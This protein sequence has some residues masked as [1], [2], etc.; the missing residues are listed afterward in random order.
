[1]STLDTAAPPESAGHCRDPARVCLAISSPQGLATRTVA[2]RM[3]VG[4]GGAR[5]AVC[6][7]HCP[8]G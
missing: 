5:L 3:R 2:W 4:I 6:A 8:R 7:R 1:M